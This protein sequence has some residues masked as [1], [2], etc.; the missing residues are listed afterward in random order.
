MLSFIV[1]GWFFNLSFMPTECY[2]VDNSFYEVNNAIVSEIGL[3]V[4]LW[5]R[6]TIAGSMES[7]ELPV[8]F[9][10]GMPNFN[11]YSLNSKFSANLRVTPN[12]SKVN[13]NLYASHECRHPVNPWKENLSTY[14]YGSTRYGI[15]VSGKF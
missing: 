3:D 9:N 1:I 14:N 2:A 8:G 5:D 6:L 11:I 7:F 15:K 10:S 12:N 4:T 13:V